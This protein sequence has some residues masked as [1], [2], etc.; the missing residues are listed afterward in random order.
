MREREVAWLAGL[1]DGEAFIGITKASTT[2]DGK[3]AEIAIKMCDQDVLDT[4]VC[5]TGLG[6]VNGPYQP[7]KHHHKEFWRWQ[8]TAKND[9]QILLARIQPYMHTRRTER[10]KEIQHRFLE[11]IGVPK[12]AREKD[13]RY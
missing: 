6:K 13:E 7:D 12:S 4:V 8:V 9:L 1:A 3:R 10:I 11:L 5:V 2:V